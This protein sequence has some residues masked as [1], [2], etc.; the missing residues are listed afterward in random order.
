M[1]END[2]RQRQPI[3]QL[4]RERTGLNG[5]CDLHP[6]P[7][8][9]Y[10]Q[11]DAIKALQKLVDT[12][13]FHRSQLGLFAQE[14]CSSG[15]RKF[16]V[17]TIAGLCVDH[18]P[19][20][21][22]KQSNDIGHYYEVILH[23]RPCWL[24]F[25]LEYSRETNP[26]LHPTVA[27]AAFETTLMAFCTMKLH[28]PVDSTSILILESSTS[29][30]FSKHVLVKRFFTTHTNNGEAV[31][32]AFANNAEAGIFVKE[33]IAFAREHRE[34]SC[35]KYLF[36]RRPMTRAG[37]ARGEATLIDDSVYSRNRCFRLLFQSKF[38][39]ETQLKL[40]DSSANRFFHEKP[41]PSLALLASMVS[42]VPINT[43]LFQ[44]TILPS[45][46]HRAE[47][48]AALR[49]QR[50]SFVAYSSKVQV[51]RRDPL[52]NH[53]MLSW[54]D[55]RSKNDHFFE[56]A[57]PTGIDRVV[58][59]GDRLRTVTLSNNRFCFCKGSS[60]KSNHIYLVVDKT[61]RTY[62]QKCYDP[63][64][65]GFESIKFDIPL[66]VFVSMRF[67]RL[68][69]PTGAESSPMHTPKTCQSMAT[70]LTSN[71]RQRSAPTA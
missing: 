66:S 62:V 28:T 59:F 25:D 46:H 39:K 51:P 48:K 49:P 56:K 2:R 33:L 4:L 34:N 9:F 5:Y 16:Y 60:H 40:E 11:D 70:Q 36:V 45:N 35:S 55:V 23:D 37:E 67:E 10:R 6:A 71:K 31:H 69:Y 52:L 12:G 54:D 26:E 61:E 42:F 58:D 30:K 3:L 24:Y 41:H 63:D 8:A 7:G 20:C 38:G 19:D 47:M 18:S 65:R 1:T 32:Q 43:M 64:C 17:D 15:K 22:T 53:L 57:L 27:L 14:T 44:H 29:E 68:A 50:S 21:W 13:G